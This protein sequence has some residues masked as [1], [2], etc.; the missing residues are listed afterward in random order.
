MWC[1]AL[2]PHAIPDVKN[3][4][5]RRNRASKGGALFQAYLAKCVTILTREKDEGKLV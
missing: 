2:L 4:Q 1:R 3:N 5:T